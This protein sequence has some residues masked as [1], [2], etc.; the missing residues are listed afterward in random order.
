[1]KKSLGIIGSHLAGFGIIV[2]ILMLSS[3]INIRLDVSK[4]NAY[5]LSK[6]SKELV[7]NLEDIMVVKIIASN[8]LPAELNSL[9][10]YVKDLLVEYQNAGGNKFR[11]ERVQSSSREELYQLAQGSRLSPMRFRIYENDQIT[12]KEVV[13][14]LAF[15][16]RGKVEPLN[17]L[18]KI[19]P[20]LEYEMTMRI[21]SLISQNMPKVAVFR[22]STYYDF[23]T[24]TFERNLK[25]NF[26]IASANL[27]EPINGI[28]VLLFTGSSRNLPEKYLYNLDQFVMKGG[29]VVFL[30]DRIDTD[31]SNLYSLNTNFIQML[32]HYGFALSEDVLLDMRCDRR[33]MGIGTIA[34]FPMYP[35][36]QGSSHP[37]SK[38]MDNIVLYLTNGISFAHQAETKFETILSSSANSGWMYA[39]EFQFNTDIFYNP[40]L[41]DFSAGPVVTAATASGNMTSYFQNTALAANDPS[42]ISETKESN[43]VLFADKELVIEPDNPTY[44]ERSNIVL[45]AI[46]HL[47]G[48]ESMIH[49]RNRHLAL[50]T[51]DLIGF[52]QKYNL[53]W[54]EPQIVSDRIKL[55]V[56]IVVIALAPLILIASGLWVAFRRKMIL[57]AIHEKI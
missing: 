15:E 23:D 26:I 3:F 49:I 41:E 18:P 22:D 39:P 53:T 17:L 9:E 36:M 29:K 47:I 19:E 6:I 44:A 16:Y 7:R 42:F 2:A 28:D 4:D 8:D 11:F 51:L 33:Q 25:S 57:K 30:Q 14:G 27:A 37:I 50:S 55:I 21:Q 52:M 12:T 20:K 46:D 32:E 13:F 38:N 40:E 5:S 10:R 1:M 35:I 56:K 34:N 45:N 54:D 31:G 24:R 48:R 43:L